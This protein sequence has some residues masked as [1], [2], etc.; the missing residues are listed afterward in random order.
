MGQRHA[1]IRN[2]LGAGRLSVRNF[3]DM[4]TKPGWVTGIARAKRRGMGN[5]AGRIPGTEDSGSIARWIAEQFDSSLD[6]DDVKR[7]R[8]R[9]K[10]K[11]VLKGILDAGDAAKAAEIG[12]DAVIVSNHGGRQLD[13]TLSSISAL[14]QIAE[15]IGDMCEVYVDSG[16]RSGRDVLKAL[17][18]G[19]SAVFVGRAFA[20]GLAAGGRPGVDRAIEILRTEL[21][22]AMAL[23]GNPSVNGIER[24]TVI[25]PERGFG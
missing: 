16:I 13:G 19:A 23:T 6:W 15:A 2:G 24:D 3:V 20:Y 21:D 5:L 14:P 4:A 11:L 12:A 10:G 18:L 25:E 22:R 7:F 9:W 17:A 8:D 1:D